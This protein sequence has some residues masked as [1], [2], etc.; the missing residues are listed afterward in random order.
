M[1]H[2]DFDIIEDIDFKPINDG[3]GFNHQKNSLSETKLAEPIKRAK[4]SE[5][6]YRNVFNEENNIL[7]LYNEIQN[8]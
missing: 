1:E 4:N 3:L 5:T 2:N 6:V 8:I 7:N